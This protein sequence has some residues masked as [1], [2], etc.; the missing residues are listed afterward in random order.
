M[1]V[2]KQDTAENLS[3][4]NITLYTAADDFGI[5]A[6]VIGEAVRFTAPIPNWELKSVQILGWNGFNGTTESMPV[7]SNFLLEIRDQNMDLLYRIEGI[8]NA[9]FTSSMPILREIDVPSIPIMG[10]FYVVFYDRGSMLVGMQQEYATGNSYFFN[11]L[12]KETRPAQFTYG[13]NNQTLKINWVI[14]AAGAERIIQAEQAPIDETAGFKEELIVLKQD[15]AENLSA[16]NIT[17]YTA[18]DDFGIDAFAIGEAVRF[19]SPKPN[20]KLKSVQILGWNGFN[21][22]AQSI[23]QQSSFLLEIRDQNKDLL[24][25]MEGV[26]NAYFTF[27]APILREIDVPSIP[28]TGDFY[29]VFYDRGSMWVGMEQENG[30]ENSFFFNGLNKKTNPAQ[31]TYGENNETLQV[32][33]VIRAAGE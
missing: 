24:Y 23:P 6:F 30:T 31:F 4:A 21:Q 17:L 15:T 7:S 9:Y 29:V 3:A 13:D 28:L 32:N 1:T 25:S 26:Q 2:L 11:N 18:V 33:W 20:W 5:D 12:N 8:Q 19:T 10:D 14:R 22:T 27:P 16:A